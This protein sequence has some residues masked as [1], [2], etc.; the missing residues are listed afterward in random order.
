MSKVLTIG[1]F[2]GLH[3]GHK[4][5]LETLTHE[6]EKRRLPSLVISYYNHPAEILFHPNQPMLLSSTEAKLQGIRELGVDEVELIRFDEEFAR[7]SAEDFLQKYLIPKHDPSLIVVG[8]DS[9]FG[10]Q[11]RGN[12]EF[13]KEHCQSCHYELIYIEPVLYEGAPISS[14]LIRA[15]LR[16]GEVETASRLLGRPY[17]LEGTVVHSKGLGTK[18]GFPTANLKL[19][20]SH[21][22]IPASGIYLSEISFGETKAFGLTNIG[23]SPTVKQD[24]KIEIETFI[25]DFKEDVYKQNMVV[26]LLQRIRDEQKFSGLEELTNAMRQDL[27]TARAIIGSQRCEQ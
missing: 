24:G 5:L 4:K 17:S 12:Y 22:L 16:A 15:K 8:F 26:S 23:T 21:I 20:S 7:T 1:N 13:L 6:A 25:I 10:H 14:S 2:D 18:L 27:E 3:L 19:H 9:H 11:R